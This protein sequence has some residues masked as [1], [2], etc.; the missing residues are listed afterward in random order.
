[1]KKPFSAYNKR[2]QNQKQYVENMMKNIYEENSPNSKIK[3]YL[4][5]NTN[6]ISANKQNKSSSLLSAKLPSV[7]QR[8]HGS[9]FILEGEGTFK[10]NKDF[11]IEGEK[12]DKLYEKSKTKEQKKSMY[13]KNLDEILFEALKK[14]TE[15]VSTFSD[16]LKMEVKKYNSKSVDNTNANSGNEE[17]QLKKKELKFLKTQKNLHSSI[18]KRLEQK[19]QPSKKGLPLAQTKF[20]QLYREIQNKEKTEIFSKNQE[21]GNEEDN[22]VQF[23][24]DPK[25]DS[26]Q[27]FLSES[28]K[29]ESRKGF[30]RDPNYLKRIED[31]KKR[32]EYELLLKSSK[33][34]LVEK[35]NQFSNDKKERAKSLHESMTNIEK[36]KKKYIFLYQTKKNNEEKEKQILMEKMKNSPLKKHEKSFSPLLNASNR[37]KIFSLTMNQK[38]RLFLNEKRS[39]SV[40]YGNFS[41]NPDNS[42]PSQKKLDKNLQDTLITNKSNKKMNKEKFCQTFIWN[43]QKKKSILNTKYNSFRNKLPTEVKSRDLLKEMNKGFADIDNILKGYKHKLSD[44]PESL[45]INL[46]ENFK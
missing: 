41:E 12:I 8:K 3:K 27:L 34:R 9:S 16:T 29:S 28:P 5:D 40:F 46:K 17:N 4:L 7:D 37:N 6:F 39:Q 13:I 36:I 24:L 45:N 14:R 43:P 1:M 33:S 19:N 22:F 38:I 32:V 26:L 42:I 25:K 23:K 11:S 31:N 30:R 2:L 15:K 18:K 21:K 44:F 35:I 20:L 10:I